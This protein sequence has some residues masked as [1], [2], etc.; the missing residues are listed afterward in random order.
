MKGFDALPA[1]IVGKLGETAA[2]EI[3]RADGAS[4]IALCRIDDG[5]APMLQSGEVRRDHRVLPDL[6]VFN[7]RQSGVRFIE[8]KTYA[9]AAENKRHGCWVHGIPV[10]LFEHYISNENITGVPVHLAINELDTGE[11]RISDVSLSKLP[12]L[13]CQ[14]RGRCQSTNS[15]LHVAPGRGICEMQWYFDREDLTIVYKHNDK[16]ISKLR[17]EHSRL[18]RGHAMQRHGTQRSPRVLHDDDARAIC[19]QCGRSS[20]DSAFFIAFTIHDR[21]GNDSVI[22]GKCWREFYRDGAAS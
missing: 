17:N 15:A 22:C 18:I 13:P 19:Q 4:T 14:C 12:R 5:G 21:F 8:I 10:R 1:A 11:L 20:S 16:T 6:Q 3:M 7:W 2:A 9:R